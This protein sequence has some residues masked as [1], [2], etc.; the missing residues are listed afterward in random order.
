MGDSA[1]MCAVEDRL[2]HVLELTEELVSLKLELAMVMK[3]GRFD[4]A[5]A[6]YSQPV[7]STQYDMNMRATTRVIMSRGDVEN[8]GS[9]TGNK[10]TVSVG[11]DEGQSTKSTSDSTR[12]TLVAASSI[13]G[14]S[15]YEIRPDTEND[16]DTVQATQGGLRRRAV[17]KHDGEPIGMAKE[18]STKDYQKSFKIAKKKDDPLF[19]FG[20]LPS[21]GLRS[22][23]GR[24][25][26]AVELSVRIAML[27]SEIR[28]LT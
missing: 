28:E 11:A 6:R 1:E 8:D 27:E 15:D 19:W 18:S 13:A 23:Q 12:F 3:Q 5:T 2:V 24:F 25:R 17:Q 22:A 9:L 10:R 14:E 7:G 4:L 20:A 16:T 26:K 21:V